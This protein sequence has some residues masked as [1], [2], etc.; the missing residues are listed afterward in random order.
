MS[1]LPAIESKRD[2][3]ALSSEQI[4]SFVDAVVKSRIPDYQITAMLMA[5]CC[6]GMSAEETS[7]LT[8]AMTRSGRIAD[9]GAIPG[10]KVDKHS[11][12]GVGDKISLP[13][14]PAVAACGGHV[15]MISGRS[16][17]HT[18]GTLDKLESIPGFRVGLSED[19]IRSQVARI[20]LAFGAATSDLAPA[21]R[22][23]YRL[24]DASGTVPSIPLIT[25][26]I[27]SK[28]IASG[29]S[30]LVLDVKT[31]SGAFMRDY[32]S[33]KALAT[34]LV[35]TAVL[36]GLPTIAWLTDMDEPLGAKV[37]NALEIEET[38]DVLKGGGPRDVVELVVLLGGEM[39]VMAGIAK[40]VADGEARI[41]RSLAD[42][43]ALTKWRAAVVAQ[44]GD[45]RTIE[46]PSRMPRSK[47][48][49]SIVAP[50]A[51]FVGRVDARAIGVAASALG[52]GRER[53]EDVVAPG[54]G[55]VLT[56]RRGDA[57]NAGDELA[58]IRYDD[59][60]RFAMHRDKILGAFEI[61]DSRPSVGRRALERITPS[62]RAN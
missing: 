17:G 15:P 38:V 13:L 16:L 40:D 33:A 41:E 24:R 14:A 30:A 27:L 18:G 3:G 26:S 34:S 47:H 42:G 59:E 21:D 12:G 1:I 51:G 11:T 5:I 25:S 43:T 48:Q 54:V 23:L 53:V 36:L 20:G 52:A 28:K 45:P 37:G 57:V 9:L 39:L 56:K 6:R 50:R 4:A 61:S 46:D 31:G 2:G 19:E 35:D 62:V 49:F 29:I 8:A 32:A 10:I 22:V 7:H 44:G 55:I 58:I 60:A